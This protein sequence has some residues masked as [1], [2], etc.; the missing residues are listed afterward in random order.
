GGAVVRWII[1][2]PAAKSRERDHCPTPPGTDYDCAPLEK[3]N[4]NCKKYSNSEE[5]AA[6]KLL[7]L[8]SLASTTQIWSTP[9]VP[10]ASRSTR[11]S[12]GSAR[13]RVLVRRL[14]PRPRWGRPRCARKSTAAT[15]VVPGLGP[16]REA[17]GVHPR[18]RA[19]CISSISVITSAGG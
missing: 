12:Q 18:G 8:P 16:C 5:N 10:H 6:K 14:A 9:S 4:S 3:E 1:P 15:L 13:A 17:L 11:G 2:L 7:S 19:V